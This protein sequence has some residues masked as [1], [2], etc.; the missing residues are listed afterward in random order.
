MNV[1]QRHQEILNDLNQNGSVRVRDLAEKF[2]VTEDLIRKDLNVLENA[3]HLKR[4]YG[5]AMPIRQNVQRI[6]ASKKKILNMEAKN[7]IAQKAFSLIQDGQVIYL[8]IS[9][10][11]VVL[12]RMIADS[13]LTVTVV[14]NMLEIMDILSHSNI[15]VVGIGGHLDYGREGFIGALA[16]ES[17]R[18]YRFDLA[19][20]GAVGIEADE[21]AVT[22]L[23][24]EEGLTKRLMLKNSA[25]RYL[26]CEEEKLR[27]QG[28]YQFA[29]IE[30]FDA[31]I[32][33]R[34]LSAS[35]QKVFDEHFV[36]V[37]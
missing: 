18:H 4:N 28:N 2:G 33:D 19:F 12:A 8:D 5:G 7:R 31:L 3:G 37:L 30:D 15:E 27:R 17:L 10:T 6:L 9:T 22:I 35:D 11:N 1:E 34:P 36:K 20:V 26:V 14:T 24:A 25:V 32:T 29:C 16:Y 13:G 23:T 21:N